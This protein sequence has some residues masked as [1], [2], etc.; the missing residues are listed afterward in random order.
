MKNPSNSEAVH[1]DQEPHGSEAALAD[2]A[3]RGSHTAFG[4]LVQRYERRLVR[5]MLQF[6]HRQE[7][8]E[9][10]A[11]EAFLKAWQ[12]LDQFDTARRFGPWLFRIGVNLALDHLRLKKRRVWWSLFSESRL[13]QGPDPATADPRAG[14]DQSQEVH[15]VLSQ[16]VESYRTVLILRDLEGFSTSEIA[17]ILNRKESTIRW[18][19]IE[20]R[21]KF[22]E[23]WSKRVGVR[24][25]ARVESEELRANSE[26]KTA[27]KMS[28]KKRSVKTTPASNHAPPSSQEIST[29]P[30]HETP[31]EDQ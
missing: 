7:S 11:Q 23:I 10:L 2:Q 26:T 3:R 14:I 15:Y 29:M 31:C 12:R 9:D 4:H 24:A 18:R 6:V 20:A 27:R 19:L 1:D 21:L 8:A 16:L 22:Q 5:L 28:P 13:E 25:V 30:P 17:A